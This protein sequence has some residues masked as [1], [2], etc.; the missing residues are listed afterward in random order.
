MIVFLMYIVFI[1]EMQCDH[2]DWQLI[3]I[4][5]KRTPLRTALCPHADNLWFVVYMKIELHLLQLKS[6]AA[7]S[8]DAIPNQACL[9]EYMKE[10]LASRN[11]IRRKLNVCVLEKL[12]IFYKVISIWTGKS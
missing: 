12:V 5:L 6:T 7:I 4:R 11:S 2:F 9:P 8:L 1:H 3:V 10:D